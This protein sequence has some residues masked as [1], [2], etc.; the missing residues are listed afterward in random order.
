[1]KQT[2]PL[3]KNMEKIELGTMLFVCGSKYSGDWSGKIT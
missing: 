2:I 3:I 1:M